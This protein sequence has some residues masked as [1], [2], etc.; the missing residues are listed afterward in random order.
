MVTYI[1]LDLLR[2][3]RAE[4]LVHFEDTPRLRQE[5]PVEYSRTLTIELYDHNRVLRGQNS[6]RVPAGSTSGLVILTGFLGTLRDYGFPTDTYIIGV[7]VDGF[8]QPKDEFVTI[9]TGCNTVEQMSLIVFRTG[10]LKVTIRSVNSQIPPLFRSWRYPDAPI[11]TEVRD[12]YGVETVASNFTRQIPSTQSVNLSVTGLRTGV[13]SIFVF[14]YGYVLAEPYYVSVMDGVVTDMAVNVVVGG[15]LDLTV[16][17]EKE[18]ILTTVDTYPFSSRVPIRIEVLDA[19]NQF[20]AA[21]A[22][23]VS[24]DQSSFTFH[25]AGFRSYAGSYT[26][27]RWVNY[28][29]TTDGTLQRDYGLAAGS[30]TFII[31]L[32]GFLQSETIV[33]A[34]LPAYGT[35]SVILH[36]DRLAHFFGHAY[37]FDK[38]DKLVPLNWVTV[39]A[40]GEKTSDFTPTLD[41]SFDLWLREGRYL[42]ILSLDGYEFVTQEISLPSGSDIPIDF[43]LTPLFA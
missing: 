32:P 27:Q 38:F 3:G 30:Y 4:I 34:V 42:V 33:T 31:Y 16:V 36:L 13:Y 28:Y 12:Q 21:N 7:T 37:S 10:S 5:T 40:V 25:L 2:A 17:L 18:G 1:Q 39:D 24:S 6:T 20:V 35:S 26:D 41:G 19:L 22:T 29:D 14:T 15:E 8:Y 23:Y 43:Y 11:R 9:S